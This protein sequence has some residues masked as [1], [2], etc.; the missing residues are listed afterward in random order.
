MSRKVWVMS[1]VVALFLAAGF[2]LALAQE[3]SSQGEVD[4]QAV[5]GSAFTYQGQLRQGGSPVNGTCDFQFSLWNAASGGTQ[6]GGT[7]TRSN[8]A[9]SNGL[10]TVEVDFGVGGIFEPAPF[11][12]EARWLAV[13]VRCP[14]G[15]GGYT[16]LTPRRPL[17]AVPYALSLRP[18]ALISGSVPLPNSAVGVVNSSN[19]GV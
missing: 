16:T 6:V 10:F 7:Q 18:G 5:V 8:V 1:I 17:T 4:I 12:G 11:T 2:V 3:T 13:A 15:T 14:T 19:G 9:V